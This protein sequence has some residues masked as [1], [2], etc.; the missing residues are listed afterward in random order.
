[1]MI[2]NPKS[3]FLKVKCSGCKNEQIIFNKPA[4]EVKCLVCEK[5]LA[6]PNG[7]KAEVK[8]KVITVLE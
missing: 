7:G 4:T 6:S 2:V 5:V 3:T 8:S 1:M